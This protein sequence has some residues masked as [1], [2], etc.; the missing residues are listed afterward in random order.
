MKDRA[1]TPRRLS[2]VPNTVDSEPPTR[3]APP[4]YHRSGLRAAVRPRVDDPNTADTLR[5]PANQ[6]IVA[7]SDDSVVAL[8]DLVQE[9]LARPTPPAS[10]VE[11]LDDDP[12]TRVQAIHESLRALGTPLLPPPFYGAAP[13]P[14]SR[15]PTPMMPPPLALLQPDVSPAP[16]PDARQLEIET[17]PMPIEPVLLAA[18]IPPAAEAPMPAPPRVARYLVLLL[19]AL[20]LSVGFGVGM[21]YLVYGELFLR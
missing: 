11:E 4:Q 5:P 2:D 7:M 10:D 6:D 1:D 20:A 19:L 13:E 15:N 12:P 17:L 21:R 14:M 3:I 8:Q 9:L 18:S 16:P